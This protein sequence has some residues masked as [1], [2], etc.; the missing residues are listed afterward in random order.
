MIRFSFG[1]DDRFGSYF[2]SFSSWN[3][4]FSRGFELNGGFGLNGLVGL[5]L[6]V[7]RHTLSRFVPHGFTFVRIDVLK[8]EVARLACCKFCGKEVRVLYVDV[9]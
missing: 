5:F 8:T 7:P 4:G 9:R 2:L 1:G 6:A 3:L